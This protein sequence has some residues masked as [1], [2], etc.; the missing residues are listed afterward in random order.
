VT[1]SAE[2]KR[3][4]WLDLDQEALDNAY[5]QTVYAPNF[6]QLNAR[7]IA[8]SAEVRRCLGE[9]QRHSYG[10][11]PIEQ[12]DL[13][14]TNNVRAPTLIIIHGGAWRGGTARD[15]ADA[16]EVF[17]RGGAHCVIPDFINVI[18]AGGSLFPMA[19]Q[20]CRAIAWVAVNAEGFGGDPDRIYLFGRSSGAH[21][22]GV[23]VVMDW[24]TIFG[25][26]KCPLKGAILS[27]GM[28]DLK[29]VRLS[30]RSAYI[31]FTDEMED[32]LSPQ[33]HVSRVKCPVIVAYGTLETPEFQRQSRD[34]ADALKRA[35]KSVR[36]LVGE[37][38]NHFELPETLGNP[39]GLL[40]RPTLELIGLR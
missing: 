25:L 12:L 21:L 6:A 29:P 5:D 2:Q 34:F 36:L 9:P 32:Q 4:V 28:Y 35:G 10:S 8:K 38:Y 39:Y 3:N 27:S 26:S 23:A 13:Y 11:T 20:V 14:M 17:V 31:R 1:Q 7:R 16:A 19:D 37:G 33:R 18:D 22:S 24:S 15:F 30:K 40:G